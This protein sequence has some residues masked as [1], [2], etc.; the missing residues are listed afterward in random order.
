MECAQL[1]SSVSYAGARC[2][3]VL[4]PVKHRP[5]D[6]SFL[7]S[8]PLFV[9]DACLCLGLSGINKQS[10]RNFYIKPGG[11]QITA[12]RTAYTPGPEQSLNL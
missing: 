11:R 12:W 5:P 8:A 2:F 3:G 10:A 7:H 1:T 4:K 9:S 6:A